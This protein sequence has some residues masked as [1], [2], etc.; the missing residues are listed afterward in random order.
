MKLGL[1]PGSFN[2]WHSGHHDILMKAL[3][4][5]DYVWVY[6]MVNP[7]KGNDFISAQDS[8]PDLPRVCFSSTSTTLVNAINQT[9]HIEGE[10]VFASG[11]IRGLRNG[12]DL[13]YE[14]NQ[15][16]WNEDVG[17]KIP[18]VYFITDRSLAHVS[19]SAIRMIEKLGLPN[20]Y[21]KPVTNDSLQTQID[22]LTN[23]LVNVTHHDGALEEYKEA[24]LP[25]VQT[26]LTSRIK[27][28]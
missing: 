14:M 15:Q 28:G 18:F 7:E 24:W 13:Q 3:Q 1:Y 9:F 4:V 6:Q 12:N 11:I 23:I 2:P 19:S 26:E 25:I 17:I 10:E 5:F 21:N 22:K 27:N 16:Y 8:I 20:K